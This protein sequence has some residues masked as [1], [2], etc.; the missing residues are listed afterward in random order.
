MVYLV[1]TVKSGRGTTDPPPGEY[2]YPQ[3]STVTVKAI[4]DVGY[5]F[6]EFFLRNTAR[7]TYY[8]GENPCTIEIP[9]GVSETLTVYCEAYFKEAPPS[10]DVKLAGYRWEIESGTFPYR[11]EDTRQAYRLYLTVRNEGGPG[12][13][14]VKVYLRNAPEYVWWGATEPELMWGSGVRPIE[15]GS[16]QTISAV[17]PEPKGSEYYETKL[18]TVETGVER[19]YRLEFPAPTKPPEEKPAEEVKPSLLWILPF[20]VA[21]LFLAWLERRR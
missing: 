19:L 10:P 17:L 5:V 16:E 6:D 15:G 12:H 4:P 18:T 11:P 9:T 13:Y 2:V 1:I 21:P 3:G 14:S 8:T 7:G 20:L